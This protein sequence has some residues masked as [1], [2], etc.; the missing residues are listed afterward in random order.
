[1]HLIPNKTE[2]RGNA[3][4]CTTRTARRPK[5]TESFCACSPGAPAGTVLLWHR[6]VAQS[7]PR[8]TDLTCSGDLPHVSVI[9]QLYYAIV[10]ELL[11]RQSDANGANSHIRSQGVAWSLAGTFLSTLV[12]VEAAPTALAN[13]KWKYYIIFVCLTFVNILIFYFWCPEVCQEK[14]PKSGQG[15]VIADT[16]L[17]L[18]VSPWKKSMRYSATK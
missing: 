10:Q 5:S 13:I 8:L 4:V 9:G 7:E 18:K 11:I 17:R 3:R 14:V 16:F 2:V 12:Y 1:M 6:R 15:C